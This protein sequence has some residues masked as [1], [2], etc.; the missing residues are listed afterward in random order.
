MELSGV[1]ALELAIVPDQRGGDARA[2]LA[3]LRLA[4]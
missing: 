3:Q 1:T 4:G 2:S